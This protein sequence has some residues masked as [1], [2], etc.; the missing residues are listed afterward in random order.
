[1]GFKLDV[2]NNSFFVKEEMNARLETA[3]EA[4]GLQAEGYAKRLCRVDTGNLRNS[5]SHTVE[6]TPTQVVAIIGTNVFY[7][8]YVE[9]G[10]SHSR[11]YPF[12]RPACEDHGQEYTAIM[13]QV[14]T[15]GGL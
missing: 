2:V 4:V 11:A 3:M 6:T 15:N 9:L 12:I 10:T 13:N 14:V 1:M 5:I 7:G 8:P